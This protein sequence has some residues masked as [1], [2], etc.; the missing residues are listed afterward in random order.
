[1]KKFDS[2]IFYFE[3]N[4]WLLRKKSLLAKRNEVIRLGYTEKI[5]KCSLFIGTKLGKQ[6]VPILKD[7]RF[8]ITR[9]PIP[10]PPAVQA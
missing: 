6:K 4:V 1:M 8:D 10:P 3:K 9:E 2:K 5:L 7:Q